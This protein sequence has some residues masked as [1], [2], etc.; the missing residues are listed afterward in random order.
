MFSRGQEENIKLKYLGFISRSILTCLLIVN[1][2]KA[3]M[4]QISALQPIEHLCK[5]RPER[6]GRQCS[7][8]WSASPAPASSQ[9]WLLPEQVHIIEK[10]TATQLGFCQIGLS[11]YQS[12]I[13]PQTCRDFGFCQTLLHPREPGKYYLAKGKQKT[14]SGCRESWET[15][16]PPP[17]PS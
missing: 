13:F 15:I 3:M 16:P 12:L 2:Q 4:H 7:H 6:W 11:T 17:F 1:F 9:A 8:P 5:S 14:N 10:C